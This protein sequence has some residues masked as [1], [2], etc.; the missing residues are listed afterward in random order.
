MAFPD[1][2]LTEPHLS[3][4][5]RLW[6]DLPLPFLPATDTQVVSVLAGTAVIWALQL[7]FSALVFGGGCVVASL[8]TLGP[9]VDFGH[10]RRPD[11]VLGPSGFLPPPLQPFLSGLMGH[12]G[13]ST[14]AAAPKRDR[15]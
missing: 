15:A 14:P 10:F 12:L 11:P 6:L 3:R 4:R 9:G 5:R 7:G 8:R 2:G 1:S 13:H